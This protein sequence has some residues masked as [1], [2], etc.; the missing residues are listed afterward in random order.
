MHL[1]EPFQFT[2]T[3]LLHIYTAASH[4]L[5]PVVFADDAITIKNGTF[6]WLKDKPPTLK[7]IDLSVRKK[8]F[9]AVVGSVGAGKSSILSAMIGDMYR[10]SGIVHSQVY[11]TSKNM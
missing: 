5:C 11:N 10:V 9:T 8:S 1:F 6:S 4:F 3:T 7:N 2:L